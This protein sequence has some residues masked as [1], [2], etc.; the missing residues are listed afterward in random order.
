VNRRDHGAEWSEIGSVTLLYAAITLVLAYPLSVHPATLVLPQGTDT[1]LML[2]IFGWDVHALTHRPWAIFNGNIFYPYDHT[3]AY[4]ENLIGSAVLSAPVVWL[5]GNLILAMNTA[6]LVS[7]V[8]CGVG[9]YVLARRLGLNPACSVV[10]GLIFA[11]APPRFFRIGQIHLTTVQWLPLC[12][13]SLIGYLDTGSKSHLRW[14]VAFFVLQTA[15]SG[16]GAALLAVSILFVL[17]WRFALGEPLRPLDRLRDLGIGGIALFALSAF[18]FLPYR[19]VQN[20]MGLRR[21]LR[22]AYLFSPSPESFLASPSHVDRFISGLLTS[23]PLVERASAFLFPGYLAILL[24]LAA[25]AMVRPPRVAAEARGSRAWRYAALFFELLAVVTFALAIK[26]TFDNGIRIRMG[27]TVVFSARQPLSVWLWTIA[28]T[29]IRLAL[30][31][32]VPLDLAGRA[33]RLGSRILLRARWLRTE[34]VVFFVVLAI[35]TTWL[36]LGPAYGLYAHAYDWP[37]FSFIRVPSRFAIVTLLAVSILAAFGVQA[38]SSRLDMRAQKLAVA[39]IGV[40]LVAEYAAMPLITLPYDAEVP[41]IDRWL[42]SQ[43]KPFVVAEFPVTERL[44]GAYMIHSTGHWQRTVHGYSGFRPDLHYALYDEMTRFPEPDVLKHLAELG[45]SQVVVHTELFDA[46]T[47]S[48]VQSEIDRSEWLT[49]EHVE[50]NGRAYRL[51]RP[52]AGSSIDPE[53]P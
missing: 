31:R 41:P 7:C 44:Q 42:D 10:A 2:W 15:T 11:F 4:A 39:V 28:V 24:S 47:R 45:V 27:S 50:G 8:L 6:A 29:G 12:L 35:I 40:A 19:A 43:P 23:T 38:L 46:D 36:A 5:T 13:A 9:S 16:H 26:A 17:V 18:F 14:A 53:L 49:L 3:L 30:T 22:D 33:Q 1:D 25:V 37:G 21:S 48:A 52:V 51:H 32:R 20:E 34:P